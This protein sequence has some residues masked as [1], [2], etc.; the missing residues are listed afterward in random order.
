[1]KRFVPLPLLVL[2]LAAFAPEAAA[3]S[4]TAGPDTSF[5][6]ESY[7]FLH[8][9]G[10]FDSS[11]GKL[12][13]LNPHTSGTTDNDVTF[14][15][16]SELLDRYTNGT[17]P[18]VFEFQTTPTNP[19][20]KS[21]KFV[22]ESFASGDLF[23]S[24]FTGPNGETLDVAC[25]ELGKTNPLESATPQ[26]VIK[27]KL[28][29]VDADRNE[30]ISAPITSFFKD[31][32]DGKLSVGLSGFTG[33]NITNARLEIETTPE[34]NL[35]ADGFESGDL[36]SWSDRIDKVQGDVDATAEAAIDGNFGMEIDISDPA[37]AFVQDATPNDDHAYRAEFKLDPNSANIAL[38][39]R[40]TV[41]SA[42]DAA[43]NF[44]F[45]LF[46]GR[47]GE[48][49]VLFLETFDKNGQSV[50]S[51]SKP[52]EDAPQSVGLS[53][54]AGVADDADCRGQLKFFINGDQQ[55]GEFIIDLVNDGQKISTAQ[56]G[57]VSGGGLSSG[58]SGKVFVDSF[59][60]FGPNGTIGEQPNQPPTAND[61]AA[62]TDEDTFVEITVLANDSDPDGDPLS[63]AI[64]G[65]PPNGASAVN[66]NVVTYTPNGDFN[67]TDSFTYTISDGKGGTDDATVTVTV[68]SVN[69]APTKPTITSPS[70][71]STFI[72]E[73][74]PLTGFSVEWTASTDV[75]GDP[76]DYRYEGA[77]DADFNQ[78]FISDDITAAENVTIFQTNVGILADLLRNANVQLGDF[79]IETFHRVSATDGESTSVGDSL[80]FVFGRGAI[81]DVED[82]PEIPRQ[83]ALHG[84]YP[85]PFN[86]ETTV[87]YDL[88]TPSAVRLE[89]YDTAG[90]LVASLA[91]EA[92][93]AGRHERTWHAGEAASGLY[94]VRLVAT[95]RDGSAAFTK[96]H[97]MVLLK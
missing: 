95:P 75:D 29:L 21:F 5:T 64:S 17:Q 13:C 96:I 79:P 78:I 45:R 70:D 4:K 46:L 55:G 76:V 20:L 48:G 81:T 88:P 73:G 53:W 35:F 42:K 25:L 23:P 86:P 34:G 89:V 37:E 38:G 61:D 39:D 6:N 77:L 51:F 28:T 52:I 90:R 92:H 40:F 69:D 59:K 8:Q 60:S 27:S 43:G 7:S 36:A 97:A 57:L 31:P 71:G 11:T 67:G 12:D 63:V 30:V 54:K 22:F 85:N 93:A 14:D 24:G 65:E 15:G 18:G 84:N 50:L 62:T 26:T 9:L 49:F 41:F 1:M 33:K 10:F 32:W 82:A 83:F 94:F 68:N 19:A 44:V 80:R 72:L 87:R 58:S 66:N 74:D 91:D 16:L 47:T 2:L 3:Q 56:L